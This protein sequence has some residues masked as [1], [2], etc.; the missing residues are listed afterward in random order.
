MSFSKSPTPASLSIEEKPVTTAISK[1]R[2]T[3]WQKLWSDKVARTAI[4]VLVLLYLGAAFADPLTPYSMG[5][6]DP[7]LANAP[8]TPVHFKD[9][10]GV[11]VWPYVHRVER[12]FDVETFKQS[13]LEVTDRQYPLKLFCPG[14]PYRL[15][16]LIPCD[17][18]VFGVEAPARLFVI[19]SDIN[20]RDSF[21]RLFF[22]AQKSLTIGFLGLL[23]AFPIGIVYGGISG[24]FGGIVDNIMMRFAEAIMSIPGFYLLIGLAAILPPSMSSSQRFALITVILSFISWAGLARIIRGMVLAVRQEEFVQAARAA[25]LGEFRNIVVHV[26]PQTS[27]FIIVAATLRVPHFILSESG[28][29]FIGLG[30]QQPDASWGNMLKFAMDNVNDLLNQP[31]LIAPGILIFITILCFNSLGDTLRDVLDPKMQGIS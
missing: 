24:F 19:G 7:D 1:K 31:W 17:I 28:L 23:I 21:S 20:G 12:S 13:Y 11:P 27:S 26:I 16:G 10:R 30:I 14:D 15:F 25:G 9:E 8:P 18:H 22:G 3:A 2:R 6:N 29:S 4:V 5:F